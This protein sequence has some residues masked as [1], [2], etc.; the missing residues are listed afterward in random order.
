MLTAAHGGPLLTSGTDESIADKHG[1]R[2]LLTVPAGLLLDSAMIVHGELRL[3]D[4]STSYLDPPAI[5]SSMIVHGEL[6]LWD[7]SASSYFDPPATSSTL[8]GEITR[9]CTDHSSTNR[10]DGK[11]RLLKELKLLDHTSTSYM[12]LATSTLHGELKKHCMW[13][14]TTTTILHHWKLRLWDHSTN[15]LDPA[16]T[17]HG[18]LITRYSWNQHT[19]I[20]HVHGEQ[21]IPLDH[22]TAFLQRSESTSKSVDDPDRLEPHIFHGEVIGSILDS[23][24][25]PLVLHGE[26]LSTNEVDP[27]VAHVFDWSSS[28]LLDGE[29]QFLDGEEEIIFEASAPFDHGIAPSPA[30]TGSDDPVL[31][32]VV[33]PDEKHTDYGQGP[34]LYTS[35]VTADGE[36]EMAHVL[37]LLDAKDGDQEYPPPK[38]H[39]DL[40]PPAEPPPAEPPPPEDPLPPAE[41]PPS[42]SSDSTNTFLTDEKPDH[43]K[44]YSATTASIVEIV[45]V[46]LT[47]MEPTKSWLPVNE[48]NGQ[49]PLQL[50]AAVAML[51]LYGEI[52][53]LSMIS[54]DDK[55]LGEV[56]WYFKP[57]CTLLILC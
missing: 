6:R 46:L 11:L 33:L 13:D 25:D 56:L 51:L 20:P 34:P 35:M 2:F 17:L 16:S 42:S 32:I 27:F 52:W 41:E 54:K 19:M 40:P 30:Y 5:D 44:Y 57:E 18:E 26:S 47:C 4:H 22:D 45:S 39:K 49:Y 43:P 21:I 55:D 23:Y 15:Y 37:N 50:L 36:H 53:Q 14:H 28:F 9:Y 31:C 29:I 1:N 3:W 12:D 38:D 48:N 7:H 24:W 10:H 8:H